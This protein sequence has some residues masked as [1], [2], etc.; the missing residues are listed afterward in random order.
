MTEQKKYLAIVLV[1]GMIGARQDIK[2]TVRMLNLE[3]K[4]SCAI[5][6]D[7]P[8]YKGMFHK[9]KDYATY[10]EITEET[11]K[12]LD[13]KREK[14]NNHYTLS[15]PKGG[16]ERNGIKQPFTTHGALGYRGAKMNDLIKKMI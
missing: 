12:A 14:K 15:P 11:I 3:R 2:D 1:R 13:A 8:V 9:I 4:F 6:E 5:V 16:F 7:S 10:G